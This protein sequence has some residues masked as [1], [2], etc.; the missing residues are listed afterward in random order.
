[1]NNPTLKSF[2]DG[3]HSFEEVTNF[4]SKQMELQG[5]PAIEGPLD[6]NNGQCFY[7]TSDGCKC[8]IGHLIPDDEYNANKERYENKLKSIEEVDPCFAIFNPASIDAMSVK[9]Y[10]RSFHAHAN[11]E[12]IKQLTCLQQ[13]HDCAVTY[14]IA[15]PTKTDMFYEVFKHKLETC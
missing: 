14:L 6:G 2:L 4:V 11:E 1:M 3:T 5:K 7:R 15:N 12:K 13:A 9:A 8:A 10:V